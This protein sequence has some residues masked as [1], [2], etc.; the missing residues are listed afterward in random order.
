MPHKLL[1]ESLKTSAEKQG[2]SSEVPNRI[3]AWLEMAERSDFP[4]AERK[5]QL[6]NILDS[7]PGQAASKESSDEN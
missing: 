7:L 1:I 6:Q 2:F 4:K 3:I 5:Q